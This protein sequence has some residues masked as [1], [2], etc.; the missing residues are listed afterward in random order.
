MFSRKFAE[1]GTRVGMIH[2][3]GV[4]RVEYIMRH[5]IG[6]N[7]ILRIN[8]ACIPK[9]PIVDAFRERSEIQQILSIC[10]FQN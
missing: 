7:V 4:Q 9:F 3:L 10:I 5:I 8:V 6:I 1:M 2:D